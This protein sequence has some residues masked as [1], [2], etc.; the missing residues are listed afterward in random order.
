MWAEEIEIRQDGTPTEDAPTIQVVPV[1]EQTNQFLDQVFSVELHPNDRKK[2]RNQYTLPQNELT[3]MPFLDTMMA[4][5]CANSTNTLDKTLQT[6]QVRVL[7][8]VGPLSLL[9]ESVKSIIDGSDRGG[10]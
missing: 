2:L 4:N 9:L 5:Q 1:S 10:C 7:E 3:K 6:I 8:A